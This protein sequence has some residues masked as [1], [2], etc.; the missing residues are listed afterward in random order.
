MR[1]MFTLLRPG[2]LSMYLPR[3]SITAVSTGMWLLEVRTFRPLPRRETLH[4]KTVIVERINPEKY[5]IKHSLN[6]KETQNEI[7]TSRNKK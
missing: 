7:K 3:H 4:L 1:V 5:L 6:P 2:L